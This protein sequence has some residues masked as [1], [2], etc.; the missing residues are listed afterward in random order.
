M[1]VLYS[2]MCMYDVTIMLDKCKTT[3]ELDG[4]FDIQKFK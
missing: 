2:Q 3:N 1:Y 4:R